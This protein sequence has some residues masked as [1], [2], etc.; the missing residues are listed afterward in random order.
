[1]SRPFFGK[2][3]LSNLDFIKESLQLV[4]SVPEICEPLSE[5]STCQECAPP[6]VNLDSI[7]FASASWLQECDAPSYRTF[8]ESFAS[9]VNSIGS[10]V[11]G[12]LQSGGW[13]VISVDT[14]GVGTTPGVD[15]QSEPC[16]SGVLIYTRNNQNEAEPIWTISA[17]CNGTISWEQA[18]SFGPVPGSSDLL[19]PKC[20]LGQCE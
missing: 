17:S 20:L 9:S 13:K 2:P 6:C 16:A 1:M 12:I 8:H 14:A 3:T 18:Q 15:W 7:P 5:P 10:N 11:S 4:D 19:I